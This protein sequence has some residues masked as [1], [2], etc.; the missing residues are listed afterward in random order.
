LAPPPP[1]EKT[2]T[3]IHYTIDA[4]Q[5]HSHLFQVSLQIDK[6]DAGQVVSLPVWIPGSYLVREFSKNLQK[7][8]SQTSWQNSDGISR[9]QKFS[10]ASILKTPPPWC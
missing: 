1:E 2:M 4:S 6:P 10:G 5:T 3:A 8:Q 9:P 7:P